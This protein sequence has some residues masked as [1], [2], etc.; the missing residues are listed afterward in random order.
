[1]ALLQSVL[2]LAK[3]KVNMDKA[4][5]QLQFSAFLCAIRP[6]FS[7]SLSTFPVNMD[8]RIPWMT[9]DDL[10]EIREAVVPT[11]KRKDKTWN[12]YLIPYRG[13]FGKTE[14]DVI[15]ISRSSGGAH[16]DCENTPTAKS[17]RIRMSPI[18]IE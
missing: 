16:T 15:V 12:P 10:S 3:G 9:T 1:M 13:L 5:D 11:L 14:I 7:P 17:K 6:F 8:E 2:K 18:E 4:A